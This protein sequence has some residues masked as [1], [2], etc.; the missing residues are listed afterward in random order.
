MSKLT[1][2]QVFDKVVTALRA[3]GCKSIDTNGDCMYR[4]L[5]NAKCAAG[6]ILPDNLYNKDIE[7]G[8]VYERPVFNSL[9][10]DTG[11]LR[12]LQR[13]HDKKLISA[14]EDSWKQLA[15]E[16]NLVYTPPTT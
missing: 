11:F 15:S 4:G 16:R 12:V 10:E 3:Q 9:V 8:I 7:Q 14:W 5:N 2:Q 1:N 6:H 13:I